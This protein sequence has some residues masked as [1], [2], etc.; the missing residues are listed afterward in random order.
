MT[1]PRL[2]RIELDGASLTRLSPLQEADR[3]QAVADLQAENRFEPLRR[4]PCSGSDGPYALRLA[5]RD[6]RLVFDIGC[7]DGTRL[8]TVAL[9]LGPLRRLMA[10]YRM[11]LDSH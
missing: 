5:I 3:A 1:E 8:R 9:A 11:L 10:D 4:T 7:L 6:G 2:A